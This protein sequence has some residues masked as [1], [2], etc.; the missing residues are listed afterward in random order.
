MKIAFQSTLVMLSLIAGTIFPFMSVSMP[1]SGFLLGHVREWIN[2]I[3]GFV[4]GFGW[5]I[6]GFLTSVRSPLAQRF[7]EI[8]W[9]LAICFVLFT[10]YGRLY[11]AEKKTRCG[12]L[13]AVAI[14]FIVILPGDLAILRYVPTW[15]QTLNVVY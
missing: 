13:L 15:S 2:P 9:P 8:A 5:F 1:H 10:L 14:S 11:D 3:W 6:V 4:F 12:T 7:G